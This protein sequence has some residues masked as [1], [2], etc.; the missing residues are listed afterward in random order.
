LTYAEELATLQTATAVS[1]RVNPITA[2]RNDG[3][4]QDSGLIQGQGAE[5][6]AATV[7]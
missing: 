6:V 2:R 3:A 1:V 4:E 5:A 7:H